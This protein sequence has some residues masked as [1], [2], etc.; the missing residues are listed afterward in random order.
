[1]LGKFRPEPLQLGGIT[2]QPDVTGSWRKRRSVDAGAGANIEDV[3]RALRDLRRETRA[4]RVGAN[5]A[6]QHVVEKFDQRLDDTL[7]DRRVSGSMPS[8]RS[9]SATRSPLRLAFTLLLAVF[10]FTLT[11][12]YRFAAMGGHF[13]GFEDD[14]F[15]HLSQAQQV[16]L[17]ERPPRDFVELGM[18]MTVGLSAAAQVIGG[19]TLLSEAALTMGMLGVC[20]A[21]LFVLG[22]RASGSLTIAFLIAL[23]QIAMAPRFYNYPKLLAYAMAIPAVWAYVARPARTTAT[24]MGIAGAAAFLL[25]HDHGV[26]VGMAALFAVIAAHWPNVRQSARDAGVALIASLVCAAPYL[27]LTQVDGGIV[28]HLSD[29]VSFATR[30]SA[31]TDLKAVTF[32]VDLSQPL[33]TRTPQAEP[34]RRIHVQWQDGITEDERR[35]AEQRLGLTEREPFSDK[36]WI[37]RVTDTG[38]NSLRAIVSD[39]R[40]IDTDGINRS[41]FTLTEAEQPQPAG[42]AQRARNLRILPGILRES[43]A[44]SFLYYLFSAIPL[45]ALLLSVR[46]WRSGAPYEPRGAAI[47]VI[48]L[49]TIVVNWALL[50]GNLPSR[51]A[52]V[53]ELVGVLGAWVCAV[54]I[55]NSSR[56]IKPLTISLLIL[57][58]ILAAASIQALE[59][60]SSQVAQTGIL[61]GPGNAAVKARELRTLM[62]AT[63]PIDAWGSDVKGIERVAHYVRTCTAPSDR[64]LAVAYTPWLYFMTGRGFAGGHVWLQARYFSTAADQALIVERLRKER[65]PIVLTVPPSR[66]SEYEA[67]FPQLDAFL[68]REYDLAGN[69]DFGEGVEYRVLTARGRTPAGEYAPLRLPCFVNP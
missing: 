14:E 66:Y 29:F 35:E 27:V 57:V 47:A 6:L 37:Y 9:R 68:N 33:W 58:L 25:R 36:V 10:L 20:A 18:P 53:T 43:N 64:V 51:L 17:G 49:V 45:V 52:D 41:R 4:N 2:I 32:D 30:A 38:T 31:Q 1:M 21:A 54:L 34:A 69:V 60:V 3:T 12:A 40:V 16:L 24:L 48:A 19:R 5:R 15:V 65:P 26:Y 8:L 11:M 44:P 46:G 67:S 59:G 7:T 42:L 13:A 63:P 39:P 56:R 23:L 62:S 28:R 55:A 61:E 50:R 22:A